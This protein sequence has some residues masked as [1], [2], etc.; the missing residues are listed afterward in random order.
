MVL[1]LYGYWRATAPY[2]VRI[3]LELKGLAFESAPVNLLKA[4]QRGDPYGALNP[5]H[6]VPT[7]DADGVLITQSLAILEWLEETHPSPPLL[8]REPAARAVV[9]AMAA[10]V[11]C[12]IHPLNNLRVLQAL[13]ELG[14]P[15]G[16]PAQAAWGKR[17]IEDGF[18]ALDPMVA[19]HGGGFAFG[20]APTLADC[21]LIPQI[22]SSS[23]FG[24]EMAAFPALAAVAQRA[25]T[26][27]A[28]IAAH[29][30]R[31]PDATSAR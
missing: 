8:P 10:I 19:R 5:Q 9:R 28:F 6:L 15:M 16:G 24:V 25:A 23:R 14:A 21:C 22:W 26:H 11:A 4:E 13:G 30:E 17:W 7:L 31:Q 20:E 12:D 29:P 27:P 1:R 3:G 2:R 18:A